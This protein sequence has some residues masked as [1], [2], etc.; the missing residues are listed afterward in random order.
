MY[1]VLL[2]ASSRMRE[3]EKENE[4]LIATGGQRGRCAKGSN[5]V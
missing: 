4:K 5:K 2:L 3:V 1:L